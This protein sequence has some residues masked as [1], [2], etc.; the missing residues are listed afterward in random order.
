[1]SEKKDD[2]DVEKKLNIE[3]NEEYSLNDDRRVKVLSPGAMVMKRFFRNR[4]AVTG[5]V[6]LAFMFVWNF[7]FRTVKL[8]YYVPILVITFIYT[9]LLDVLNLAGICVIAGSLFL[10]LHLVLLFVYCLIA[11]PM[12][13][14]GRK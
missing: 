14:M 11:A 8:G 6:I 12:Y 10:L 4:V 2:F 5:L 1:M 13:V 7:L 9:I 3:E